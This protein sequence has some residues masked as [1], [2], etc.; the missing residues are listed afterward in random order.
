MNSDQDEKLK[1]FMQ[2]NI[3]RAAPAPREELNQIKTTL[4]LTELKNLSFRTQQSRPWFVM[5]GAGALV[6]SFAASWF[7]LTG[8]NPSATSLEPSGEEWAA[9]VLSDDRDDDV[10]PTNDIGEEYLGLLAGR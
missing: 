9:Q 2:K 4:G 7:L 8:P 3:H 5:G 1:T 10:L 6:A